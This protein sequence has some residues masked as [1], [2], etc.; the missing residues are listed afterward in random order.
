MSVGAFTTDEAVEPMSRFKWKQM[1]KLAATYGVDDYVSAGIISTSTND[2]RLIPK[3]IVETAYSTY[4]TP[5]PQ[6]KYCTSVTEFSRNSASKFANFHLNRKLKGLVYN[7]IH[8][9][10]TSTATLTFLFLVIDNINGVIYGGINFRL[11][12]SLGLYL[13][14]YGDKIDFVKA[15]Q[16]L[17]Q[18]GICRPANLIGCYLTN[19]FGFSENEVHLVSKND[20]HALPKAVRPLRYTLDRASRESDTRDYQEKIARR[21]HIPDSRILGRFSYFPIE[22]VSKFVTGIIRSLSNIEE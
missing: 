14:T 15:D 13:R 5:K 22:V 3:D 8:S 10:D 12:I 6:E 11:M 4:N 1:L 20:K 2:S 9:I 7:E 19:V 16:W 17:R 21:L 18:L